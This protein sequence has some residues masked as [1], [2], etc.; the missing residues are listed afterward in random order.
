V[1]GALLGVV[2]GRLGRL[3]ARLERSY[4]VDDLRLLRLHGGELELLAGG[5]AADQV[6][7]L[8][9]VVVLVLVGVELGGQ[10]PNQYFLQRFSIREVREGYRA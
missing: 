6:E 10:R 5:L 7:D 1:P 4:H 3:D 8:D 2:P 9:P